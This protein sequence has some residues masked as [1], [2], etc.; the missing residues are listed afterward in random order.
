MLGPALNSQSW[1]LACGKIGAVRAEGLPTF[2]GTPK[3]IS[4]GCGCTVLPGYN[5][6]PNV[7][8][9]VRI[10][11]GF[12]IARYHVSWN[13]SDFVILSMRL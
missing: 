2:T 12:A 11:E 5:E 13:P 10:V 3:L 7:R 1:V 8:G 4:H 9:V 6:R